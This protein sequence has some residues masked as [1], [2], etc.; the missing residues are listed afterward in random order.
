MSGC[1]KEG[2]RV[3]RRLVCVM[4]CTGR[5]AYV[6]RVSS[7]LSATH[8]LKWVISDVRVGLAIPPATT[9]LIIYRHVDSG[10]VVAELQPH[11]QRPVG[12]ALTYGQRHPLIC[13]ARP[14]ARILSL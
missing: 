6:H 12:R 3:V 2:V 10:D 4:R 5:G 9:R 13:T 14:N 1:G 8:V 11:L 7:V